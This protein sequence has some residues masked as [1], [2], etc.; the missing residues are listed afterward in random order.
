MSERERD[1]KTDRDSETD[2]ERE[3]TKRETAERGLFSKNKRMI[4]KMEEKI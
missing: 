4:K 2:K 1:K 3:T